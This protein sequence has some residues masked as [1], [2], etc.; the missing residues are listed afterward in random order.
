MP[1]IRRLQPDVALI[2]ANISLPDAPQTLQELRA[3]RARTR[4]CLLTEDGISPI[5]V[6][7]AKDGAACF[8]NERF[9]EQLQAHFA[10]HR[11]HFD[12]R[13]SECCRSSFPS[14]VETDGSRVQPAIAPRQNQ[15]VA[16]LK[17]GSTNRQIAHLLGLT[18]GTVRSTCI[19]SIARSACQTG[20]N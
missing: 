4:V 15:I 5:L 3:D 8:V 19:E 7:A 20:P 6:E 12:L 13:Q 9:P 11:D 10:R 17:I 2:D 18:E 16:M 14:I 1:G